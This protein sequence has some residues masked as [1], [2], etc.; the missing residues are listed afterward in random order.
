MRFVL[1]TMSGYSFQSYIYYGNSL[2]MQ[3]GIL[4]YSLCPKNFQLGCFQTWRIPKGHVGRGE[5]EVGQALLELVRR[6]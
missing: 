3:E 5:A 2:T 1:L 6:Y 4:H